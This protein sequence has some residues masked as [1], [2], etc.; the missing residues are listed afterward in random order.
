MNQRNRFF[1]FALFLILFF[2]TFSCHS[3]A[4]TDINA[5][6]ISQDTEWTADASPYVIL[7]S[8]TIDAGATLTIDP[9]VVVKFD[10]NQS[11][12]IAGNLVARG[13]AD[14]KIYF[15][16]LYDDS[17]GGDTTPQPTI[18]D[19]DD[20]SSSQICDEN[21]DQDNSD[22]ANI[23]ATSSVDENDA[24][25]SDQEIATS[26]DD[27]DAT[28]SDQTC[29]TNDSS[30]QSNDDTLFVEPGAS[31]GDWVGINVIAGGSYIV[32]NAEISYAKNAIISNNATGT[33]ESLDI[34]NSTAGVSA[35]NTSTIVIT[36]TNFSNISG[37]GF[38][39]DATSTASVFDSSFKNIS[40]N[41]IT[42]TNT[43]SLDFENSTMKNISGYGLFL[44]ATSTAVVQSL[45]IQNST[46]GVIAFYNSFL[47]LEN[48]DMNNLSGRGLMFFNQSSSTIK[49]LSIK[50]ATDGILA[51]TGSGLDIN[52]MN[53]DGLSG[54]GIE[55]FDDSYATVTDINMKN[56]Q[57]GIDIF[58]SNITL[59]SSTIAY[60]SGYAFEAFDGSIATISHS[61]FSDIIP[62]LPY[63]PAFIIDSS[64]MSISD[65]SVE[66]MTCPGF[67]VES[68]GSIGST[69]NLDR[70]NILNGS[71]S[72]VEVMSQSEV[73]IT[74]SKIDNFPDSGWDSGVG[75]MAFVTSNIH[76]ANSEISGNDYGIENRGS[77]IDI[78]NSTI[79]NNTSFGIYNIPVGYAPEIEGTN[80]WWGDASGPYN[81]NLNATGTANQVS[82][83]VSFTP[84]LTA[85][86]GSQKPT[87][88]S[89][90]LFIPGLEAS[91]LYEPDYN[92]GTTRLWQPELLIHDNSKLDLYPDG[93]PIQSDIYTKDIIDNAYVSDFGN[94]Y[95]SFIQTMNNMKSSG[96]INDWAAAPYDWRLS[97]DDILNNGNE[98]S[99][100]DIYYAG[101]NATTSDPYI[102]SELRKLAASSQTGKV[103][104]IAHSNGGLV[105]KALTDKLGPEA[106]KLIDQII[107]VAV[108]QVGTPSAIGGILHG[109]EQSLPIS[110]F[111]L[112]FTPNDARTLGQNMPSAYNLLP[113]A[114]YFTSVSDPVVTFDNS[115]FLADWRAKYGDAITTVSGL[116]DFLA[117]QSRDNLPVTDSLVFPI[118]A[119][120]S[121]LSNAEN[122]HDN[123]LDN[124]TPPTG[125][126]L[127]EIAGWGE[128]TLKGIDY[129]QGWDSVCDEIQ[130]G[131]LCTHYKKVPVLQY[132]PDITSDGD[133]TVVTPSALWTVEATSTGKYWVNLRDYNS[134]HPFITLKGHLFFNHIDILE[135]S[136]LLT[137]IQNII[138]KNSDPL[139]T[140][141]ST[142][143]PLD[144]DLTKELHFILH[145]PLSLGIY[146]D[147]GNFTGISSST[148]QVE[149]NIP[150]SDYE[151]FGEVKYISVPA[152]STVR[153]LMNGYANGSF[154]L[155]IQET[156]GDIILASTTFAGIPSTTSTVATLDIPANG[157]IASTSVLQVDE[158]GDGANILM[159]TPVLDGIVMP[160]FSTITPIITPTITN[161]PVVVPQSFSTGFM[162]HPFVISPT[163]PTNISS[164][165][166]I[167]IASTTLSTII[168]PQIFKIKRII[169]A[170]NILASSNTTTTINK[171]IAS[172]ISRNDIQSATVGSFPFHDKIL[173][174]LGVLLIFIFIGL[175]FI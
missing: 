137:F 144:T 129:I 59:A 41:A 64:N 57:Q 9:G 15:T 113:S 141:F 138:T 175:K 145:S 88:C 156:Q 19:S 60:V 112:A 17:L 167:Q 72:A 25:S 95:Y 130:V 127:T 142:S 68:S 132:N 107:F 96:E 174:I 81:A 53:I 148:G 43:S 8:P 1:L 118:S 73:N 131:P 30:D 97:L 62:S 23:D 18:S 77:S 54:I 173:F 169:M 16:S 5:D 28:S 160:S 100:G 119:N 24:S 7:Q 94:I 116:Y 172:Q 65:S 32:K 109:F 133:G 80:N 42:V 87:C 84:W 44:F 157:G 2:V 52:G 114:D 154:T 140:Y 58:N 34:V 163:T 14:Q 159:F 56:I 151:T 92:G 121:L 106:S 158:N 125:V 104:I 146:D 91:R 85:A 33:L 75:I 31:L 67:F 120:Q 79:T 122:V 10:Y 49:N 143:T 38:F 22:D 103:T 3:F 48:S 150:G 89:N 12:N 71:S 153:V 29:S 50:S 165:S 83:N 35:I 111:P 139:P 123:E 46:N 135:V 170:T 82:D 55:M 21:S 152:S 20:N 26:S 168:L 134:N 99:D 155:D 11:L 70:S 171:T 108:P 117:D 162:S 115:D 51:F 93:E 13:T 161:T 166:V 6:E 37:D 105:T 63:A 61:I 45:D 90:V 126:G 124:W 136:N 40:G 147:Q 110:A 66:N 76:I 128:D 98:N 101:D 27:T 78:E 4:E 164:S 86:P 69:L 36:N 102:I 74:N 39:L 47:D 149:E